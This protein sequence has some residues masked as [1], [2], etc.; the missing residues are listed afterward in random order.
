MR[1]LRRGAGDDQVRARRIRDDEPHAWASVRAGYRRH[2]DRR[3]GTGGDHADMLGAVPPNGKPVKMDVKSTLRLESPETVR[4]EIAGA[5]RRAGRAARDVD[6]LQTRPRPRRRDDSPPTTKPKPRWRRSRGSPAPGSGVEQRQR[7]RSRNAGRRRPRGSMIGVSRT[8]RDGLMSAFEFLC[9]VERDGGLVYQAMPNGRSPATDFILTKIDADNAMFENP[10]HDFPKM[11]RY[12]RAPTVRSKRSSAALRS[13][14]PQTFVFKKQNDHVSSSG[15]LLRRV[16]PDPAQD[17]G[18]E[19]SAV[20]VGV[21]A[22]A[23]LVLD[24]VA[25]PGSFFASAVVFAKFSAASICWLA[26]NQLPCCVVE[27]GRAVLQ[28]DLDRLDRVLADERR[29]EIAARAPSAGRPAPAGSR[30]TCSC[31]S[32]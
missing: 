14:K 6:A 32:C 3:P 16:T 15:A 10:A 2:V 18:Q 31:R 5:R 9:I 24:L 22:V 29:V 26:R 28:E 21:G 1:T 8:L 13:S 12:T 4:V 7:Q 20:R 19:R 30:S 23:P 25:R 27:I 11:I 17:V